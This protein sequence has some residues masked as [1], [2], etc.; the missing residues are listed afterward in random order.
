M[1]LNIEPFSGKFSDAPLFPFAVLAFFA[2]YINYFCNNSLTSII[3]H[4]TLVKYAI[5]FTHNSNVL[6]APR[7]L[8]TGNNIMVLHENLQILLNYCS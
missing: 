4:C 7:P 3:K 1:M 6:F 2:D 5:F 8:Y